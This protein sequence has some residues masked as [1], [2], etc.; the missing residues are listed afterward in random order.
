[1]PNVR[2][3]QVSHIGGHRFAPTAISLPDGRYYGRL[4]PSALCAIINRSGSIDQ[5]RSTYRGWSLLPPSV[6][7]LE[8]QLLLSQGWSWLNNKIAYQA[9]ASP[10]AN[11][12]SENNLVRVKLSVQQPNG[13]II[14]HQ[15]KLV[16]DINQP[17]CVKV[18]CGSALPS[19]IVKYKVTEYAAVED[20]QPA[21][22]S[23]H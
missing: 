9:I 3:W 4:T 14:T 17:D 21:T 10:S 2:I 16:R 13:N 1:M 11:G 23:V 19:T 5:L 8:R 15:A 22:A 7:V 6:Q 12:P 20:L 18:S